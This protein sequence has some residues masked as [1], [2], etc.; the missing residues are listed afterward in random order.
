MQV[1]RTPLSDLLRVVR[2]DV[3]TTPRQAPLPTGTLEL[4]MDWR[5][6]LVVQV[7]VVNT[8]EELLLRGAA[9]AEVTRW[10]V[11]HADEP[12][13]GVVVSRA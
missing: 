12:H 10:E 9:P 5:L 3:R 1:C 2:A 4:S 6:P 7:D 11:C 8:V 13:L